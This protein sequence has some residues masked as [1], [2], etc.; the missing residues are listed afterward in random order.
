[1]AFSG[2]PTRG[3]FFSS[4]TSGCFAGRPEIASVSRLG[5]AKPRTAS[6]SSPRSE[7]APTTS[8]SRSFAACVCMRAGISS[9]K[10]SRSRSGICRLLWR[11]GPLSA[12][13]PCF[14]S[15]LRQ[16]AHTSDIGGPFRHADDAARV[17]EIE[18][19][20]CLQDL[21]IGRQRELLRE[22]ALALLLGV[23]EMAKQ[24]LG[25]GALEIVFRV[26]AFGLVK[27]FAVTEAVVEFEIVDVLDALH[28]HGQ[29]LETIGDLGGH[30]R[31]VETADLLEIGE[32]THLHTVAP[33][34][35][36]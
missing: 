16:N 22:Q 11:V 14:A 5:P 35:P 10:S 32:L 17:E 9:E 12:G 4:E 15:G 34:F 1:M 28:I 27:D 3:P 29:A 21:V 24:D 33:H 23:G 6:N 13:E 20:A 18:D 30:R 8:R 26:F 36:A 19:V 7:S 25:I 2:A 31:A